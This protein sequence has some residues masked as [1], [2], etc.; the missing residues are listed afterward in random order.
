MG[1]VRITDL[2]PYG[3]Y[4]LEHLLNGELWRVFVAP[5]IHTKQLHMF[6]NALSIM[7]LG[8]LLERRLGSFRFLLIWFIAGSIGTLVSTFTVEAPWNLGT[9]G[10]QGILTV[11]AAGVGMYVF[12]A[13]RSRALALVLVFTIAPAFALD[14]VFASNHL[15]KLGHVV[16]FVVGFVL[17][18]SATKPASPL[19]PAP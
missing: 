14:L 17:V 13:Y 5:F 2:E 1:K 7:A 11:A 18:L 3:G 12:S 4:T 19:P 16:S 6:Y 15:P 8:I 9:G 10:S